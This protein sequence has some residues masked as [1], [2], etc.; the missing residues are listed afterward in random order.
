[1][2]LAFTSH[3]LSRTM[4]DSEIGGEPVITFYHLNFKTRW[5]GK[6]ALKLG[7]CRGNIS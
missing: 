6:R 1:M 3:L 5:L 4:G 7:I 2:T